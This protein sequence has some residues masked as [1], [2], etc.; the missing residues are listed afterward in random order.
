[1]TMQG[2]F[3]NKAQE[4]LKRAQEAALKLGNKYVG[5]EHI[6]L[7]LTLVSDSVAAKAL[8]SQ[9]VTYHQVMDKIQ[10]MTGEPLL[11]IF[12]RTLHLVQNVVESSVQEAFRMG[13]GYVGTEHI[14]IALIRENDNIAVRIMVSLDLNLQRLYDDI[15]NMLGEGKT[16]TAAPAA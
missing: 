9:G 3:T 10:S 12:L 14:L 15:M 13:T 1:M 4:V 6:L 2:K 11:T 16:R 5:T 8:E 7:G